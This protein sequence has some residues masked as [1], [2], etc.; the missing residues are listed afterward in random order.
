MDA[1]FASTATA[2]TECFVVDRDAVDQG[3]CHRGG[4]AGASMWD[5]LHPLAIQDSGAARR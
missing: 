3:E 1:R 4:W 2:I 5:G